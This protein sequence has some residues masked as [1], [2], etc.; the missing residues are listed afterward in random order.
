MMARTA[1]AFGHTQA[2]VPFRLLKAQVTGLDAGDWFD[3][4]SLDDLFPDL[5]VLL[6]ELFAEDVLDAH[7]VRFYRHCW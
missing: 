3:I 2:D 4:P 1:R 7:P 6:P 5:T